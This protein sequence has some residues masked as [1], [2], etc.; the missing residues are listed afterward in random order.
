VVVTRSEIR[1][2]R[3]VVKQLPV[4]M[5]KQYSNASSCMLTRIAIEEHYT[6]CQHSKTFVLNGPMQFFLLF[7]NTL[8]TLLWSLVA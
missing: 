1:A 5:L 3:R 4:K 6:V 8:V 2:A 7:C